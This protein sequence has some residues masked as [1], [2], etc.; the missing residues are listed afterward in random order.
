M[1]LG[2]LDDIR[3]FNDIIQEPILSLILKFFRNR[4]SNTLGTH[5]AYRK[6]WNGAKEKECGV[7]ICNGK[8]RLYKCVYVHFFNVDRHNR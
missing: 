8:T 4:T 3:H 7:H 1:N 2:I 5:Y 6:Q